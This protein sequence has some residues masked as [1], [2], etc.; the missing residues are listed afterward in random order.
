MYKYFPILPR[1]FGIRPAIS[2]LWWCFMGI[3]HKTPAQLAPG[4]G[5]S[6]DPLFGRS[7][8]L[9][10]VFL[11]VLGLS[12]LAT[13]C[14]QENPAPTGAFTSAPDRTPRPA[15]TGTPATPRP[16]TTT[17]S[18]ASTSSLGISASDLQGTNL[19]FWHFFPEEQITPLLRA[20]N[21]DN[22]WGIKVTE[23]RF[24]SAE[25]LSQALQVPGNA[26]VIVGYPEQLLAWGSAGA[27]ADLV[28]YVND[29]EWGLESGD[30]EDY[31][32]TFWE[33]DL[34]GSRRLGIPARRN[35]QFFILNQSWASELGYSTPPDSPER[36]QA[37]A[38]TANQAMKKD[39]DF[40]NDS[41]GGWLV[42]SDAP[43]MIGWIK[44][45]GGQLLRSNQQ[46]YHFN[47][48]QTE[49]AFT[50]LKTLIDNNCAW[51]GTAPYPDEPF[52]ARQA[53]FA[54][55]NLSDLPFIE[56]ALNTAANRDRWRAIAF[57]SEVDESILP[58]YGPSL[59]LMQDTPERKLA[60]WLFIRWLTTP[61]TQAF[62]TRLDG[63][64]PV[65]ATA[66]DL[67]NDYA[68]QHIQWAQVWDLLKYSVNE[69][70]LASWDAVQ[71]A[72]QDAGTQ[73]FRSYF[74]AERIPA[75]LQELDR[76]ALELSQQRP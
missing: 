17:P 2:S 35:A 46:S 62:W 74:T 14:G 55:A 68:A 20:F 34:D 30:Q 11:L 31:I 47:T 41:Q 65:R 18:P 26:P 3:G 69:P 54:T 42:N 67:L 50:F 16:P 51:V 21:Q 15:T 5:N 1:L 66:R 57:P 19:E 10:W 24:G 28:P 49:Q 61:E 72:V 73:I 43:T 38:C 60:G 76:T 71:W 25:S 33:Q 58:V 7:P 27:L 56:Q 39:R 40:Q 63:L 12:L 44:A 75:T 22:P 45:F 32:E 59:A 48:A 29:P 70:H 13:A 23:R 36:F 8:K 6:N 9:K 52:G 37:Q 4:S 53:L 64:L